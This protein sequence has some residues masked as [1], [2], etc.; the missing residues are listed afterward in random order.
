M[1][2]QIRVLDKTRLLAS[3]ETLNNVEVREAVRA[4]VRRYLNLEI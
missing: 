1:A 3:Y 4:A 2:Q